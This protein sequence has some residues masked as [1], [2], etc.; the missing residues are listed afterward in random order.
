MTVLCATW[1]VPQKRTHERLVAWTVPRFP[2]AIL[3]ISAI[4][5]TISY[6]HEKG[7]HSL[8]E[9]LWKCITLIAKLVAFLLALFVLVKLVKFSWYF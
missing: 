8:G 1:V 6:V 5:G 4:G 3:C 2:A 7:W 9:F